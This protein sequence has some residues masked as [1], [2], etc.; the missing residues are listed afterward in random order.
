MFSTPMA[1]RLKLG[2]TSALTLAVLA[3]LHTAPAMAAAAADAAAATNED[4]GDLEEIVVTAEKRSE[5]LEV[6]PASITA[7]SSKDLALKGVETVQD[8]TDYTPGLAYT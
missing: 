1:R 5:N 3:T 6:V 7:F 4:S 2:G 8:L